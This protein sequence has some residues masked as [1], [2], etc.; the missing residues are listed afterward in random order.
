MKQQQG[1]EEAYA[2]IQEHAKAVVLAMRESGF[3]ENDFYQRLADDPR[4]DLSLFEIL[5][6]IDAPLTFVGNA[7]QQTFDFYLGVNKILARFSD[8]VI[9]YHPAPIL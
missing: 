5:A 1:R 3:T 4:I 8:E 2:A 9:T 6:L 7:E